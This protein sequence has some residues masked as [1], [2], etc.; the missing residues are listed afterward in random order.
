[1]WSGIPGI[2]QRQKIIKSSFQFRYEYELLGGVQQQINKGSP[3]SFIASQGKQFFKLVDD[4]HQS[5]VVGPTQ[6]VREIL[7]LE[8]TEEDLREYLE[9]FRRELKALLAK[10]S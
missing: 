3:L 4:Q 1:V 2:C 10:D 7:E 6:K 5:D 9:L 8:A